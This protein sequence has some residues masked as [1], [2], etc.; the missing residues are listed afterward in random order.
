MGQGSSLGEQRPVMSSDAGGQAKPGGRWPMARQ[1][2]VVERTLFSAPTP[3]F[4]VAFKRGCQRDKGEIWVE[5]MKLRDDPVSLGKLALHH[6]GVT[7]TDYSSHEC[8]D[9]CRVFFLGAADV[10]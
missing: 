2:L 1:I 7:N 4:A 3:V 10:E 6:D 5:L 9:Q 8:D